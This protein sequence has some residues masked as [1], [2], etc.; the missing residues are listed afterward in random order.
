MRG[1]PF[2][3]RVATRV[4][5]MPWLVPATR[6]TS[7][8]H[9]SGTMMVRVPWVTATMSMTEASGMASRKFSM[10]VF[11]L[12]PITSMNGGTSQAPS[13]F[14]A[15]KPTALRYSGSSQ[16]EPGPLSIG[17]ASRR[18]ASRSADG[19]RSPSPAR[20][21]PCVLASRQRPTRPPSSSNSIRPSAAACLVTSTARSRSA[22]AILTLSSTCGM[23]IAPL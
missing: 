10:I 19:I 22:G 3:G 17:G 14:R 9:P 8:P 13:L 21:S 11:M 1:S 16:V 12:V 2:V 23:S 6:S 5:N 7:T 18:K 15:W 20:R 4:L